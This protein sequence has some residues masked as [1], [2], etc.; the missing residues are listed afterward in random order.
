M[1]IVCLNLGFQ[2]ATTNYTDGFGFGVFICPASS[3]F[4]KWYKVNRVDVMCTWTSSVTCD[5]FNSDN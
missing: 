5:T 4:H 3:I 2:E 1:T